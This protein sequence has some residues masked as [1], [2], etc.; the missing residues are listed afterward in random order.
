M[1]RIPKSLDG[2]VVV[3]RHDCD[4]GDITYEVWDHSGKTYHM[5]CALNELTNDNAKQEAEFIAL[6]LNNAIG[7]LKTIAMAER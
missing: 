1:A 2:P 3:E 7:A 4:D 5:I 6:A